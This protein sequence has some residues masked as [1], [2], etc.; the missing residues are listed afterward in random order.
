MAVVGSLQRLAAPLFLPAG[1]RLC[2][3]SVGRDVYDLVVVGGGMVGS[4]LAC[5]VGK[6]SIVYVLLCH[7]DCWVISWPSSFSSG[8]EPSFSHKRVLLLESNPSPP[9][10]ITADDAYSNR[11]STLSLGSVDLMKSMHILVHTCRQPHPQTPLQLF[12]HIMYKKTLAYEGPGNEARFCTCATIVTVCKRKRHHIQCYKHCKLMCV[13]EVP[14]KFSGDSFISLTSLPTC[15]PLARFPLLASYAFKKSEGCCSPLEWK[16]KAIDCLAL[17]SSFEWE[18]EKESL[19]KLNLA[20][21]VSHFC[22]GIG[23]WEAITKLRANAFTQLH[24]SFF[25]C[26]PF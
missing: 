3:S 17:I 9:R 14:Q 1:R 22:A 24:V 20:R 10:P 4:A 26:G 6:L 8:R 25:T 15:R 12:S 11:V 16:S 2:S 5:N 13:S 21:V 18:R 7:S 19:L 23:A